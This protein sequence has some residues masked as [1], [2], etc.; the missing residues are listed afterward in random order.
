Q[1]ASL[2]ELLQQN[3]AA[4]IAVEM[5]R[6]GDAIDVSNIQIFTQK[7]QYSRR[8]LQE[9]GLDALQDQIHALE[10]SEDAAQHALASELKQQLEW[11]R[12]QVRNFVEQQFLLFAS[13]SGQKLREEVLKK[14]RLSS[15]DM[16]Y[17]HDM[18]LL[19]RKM[20]KKLASQHA[21]RKR[22]FKKGQ[23]DAG[24]TIGRNIPN[25]GILF[26][27]HWKSKRRE[28]PKV[29]AICDVSGSVSLYARFLLMLLYSLHEVLPKVRAFAFSSRLGEVSETFKQYPLEKAIELVNIEWGMG[30]TDYGR[31]FE[32]F[33]ELCLDSIDNHSTIIILGDARNNNGAAK[34]DLLKT[35][36]ERSQRVLWIN[37]ESKS[38]WG[39][40]DSEMPRY[41][42]YCHDAN[43]CNTLAQLEN[44]VSRLLRLTL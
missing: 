35:L 15:L 24:K 44:I 40:G 16:H 25:D 8:M 13:N 39:S 42:A 17:H 27:T 1:L 3:D 21:R 14:A 31:A 12:D 5:A 22:V 11:L 30:S 34:A 10:Q 23:L 29:F 38:I 36:Y 43:E 20:A 9:M 4:A 26:D 33:S 37:P 7:G 19:V 28:R 32:D 6:A 2:A 41:A 18:Q